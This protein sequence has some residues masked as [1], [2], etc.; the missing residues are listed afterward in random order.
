MTPTKIPASLLTYET[1]RAC[2]K[3]LDRKNT[4]AR[5]TD[6]FAVLYDFVV[7][8]LP[9]FVFGSIQ[10]EVGTLSLKP[11]AF[12]WCCE[13]GSSRNYTHRIW[14]LLNKLNDYL[15]EVPKP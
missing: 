8:H 9:E 6:E 5:H 10:H 15:P 14:V 1:L 7:E 12:A 11:A 4:E 3:N 2:V 13:I